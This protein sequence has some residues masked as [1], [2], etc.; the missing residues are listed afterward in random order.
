MV[1]ERKSNIELLRII[2]MIGVILLHF[3]HPSYGGALQYVNQGSLNYYFIHFVESLFIGA[4]NIFVLISA[5]FLSKTQK[6]DGKKILLL[7]LQV[8][9]FKLG[10]YLIKCLVKKDVLSLYGL[11]YAVIPNNYFVILYGALYMISPYINIMV[12]H[13]QKKQFEKLLFMMILLFSVWPTLGDVL[14]SIMNHPL[15][16]ISSIGLQGSQ[17]GYTIVNFVLLY[18]FGAYFQKNTYIQFSRMKLIFLIIMTT[19]LI[20]L[21]SLKDSTNAWAYCNPLVVMQAVFVFILFLKIDIGSSRTINN[22]ATATFTVYLLNVDL[23]VLCVDK[24]YINKNIFILMLYMFVISII[25]YVICWG[26]SKIYDKAID[27]ILKK[28]RL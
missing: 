19:I 2:I 6:R 21:W 5:F 1:K 17:S 20:T 4:V 14:S 27:I 24:T 16:G 25:I 12:D 15:N 28:I 3:N 8:I 11:T 22:L 26:V 7:I 9:L 18:L 10:L 13:I 23:L